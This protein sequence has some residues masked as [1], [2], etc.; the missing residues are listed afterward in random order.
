MNICII[1]DTAGT[2]NYNSLEKGCG[3]S[4]TWVL[5]L[6]EEFVKNNDFVV[7]CTTTDESIN[8]NNIILNNEKINI[9]PLEYIPSV[10]Q[11]IKFDFIIVSRILSNQ[12]LEVLRKASNSY[13]CLFYQFHDL[14]P[15]EE[16]Y[17]ETMNFVNKVIAL[18]PY[19][20]H[21]LHYKTDIDYSHFAIIPNGIDLSLFDNIEPRT[22]DNRML[23]CSNPDR[24]LFIILKYLYD[25]IKKEI[26][27]FGIDIA[28]PN[29]ANINDTENVLKDKDVKFLGTLSKKDLYKEMAKHK[30]WCYPQ[31]FID[32][33][34]ICMLENAYSDVNIVAPWWYAPENIFENILN[35]EKYK[36]IVNI[37]DQFDNIFYPNEMMCN[38]DESKKYYEWLKNK[39][40][41]GIKNY[42]SEENQIKRALKKNQVIKRYTWNNVA[43][44][45]KSLCINEKLKH[46]KI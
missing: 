36:K 30:C 44:L 15:V 25:D 45:Y 4:E 42:D 16:N 38:K 23:W 34:C 14:Y 31:N 40:I 24:G 10:L 2:I 28:Y 37:P 41:D 9:V 27:D 19:H 1:N 20:A 32:T 12:L 8:E 22:R 26:P 6:G 43:N 46:N 11:H 17:K 33:F 7:I 18:T 39:I 35:D 13:D 5:Q 29:Y 3:G 21:Y